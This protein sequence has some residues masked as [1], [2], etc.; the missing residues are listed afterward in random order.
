MMF[1]QLVTQVAVVTVLATMFAIGLAVGER[2]GGAHSLDA[3]QSAFEKNDLIARNYNWPVFKQA[4][5]VAKL[6]CSDTPDGS[7][8]ACV[9]RSPGYEP[10]TGA[11]IG[12]I[13]EPFACTKT[14]CSWVMFR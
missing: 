6:Q 1:G 14:A 3:A 11:P 7:L 8:R 2:F 4:N 10:T 9:I 12:D 5:S 13:Y